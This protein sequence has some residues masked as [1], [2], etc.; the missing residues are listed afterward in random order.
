MMHRLREAMKRD[1]IAGLLSGRVVADETFYGGKAKNRHAD[2]RRPGAARARMTRRRSCRSS[3]ARLARS[4]RGHPE[5]SAENLR[6]ILNA[7]TQPAA[8][9]LHTDSGTPTRRSPAFAAIDG[10]PQGR[11]V[12]APGRHHKPSRDLLRPA[13]ALARRDVP[14]RLRE[15]LD[16][17]VAEFDFRFTT[18]KLS[19]TER[20]D[21]LVRRTGGRRLM[22]R[23]PAEA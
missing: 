21:I 19:D 7:N 12:R 18:C 23:Q 5:R 17:Y 13:Q 3:P 16:R 8:T 20:M 9:H 4:D 6:P 1:P 11:R 10:Q 22:Y 14:S 2:K 15:H